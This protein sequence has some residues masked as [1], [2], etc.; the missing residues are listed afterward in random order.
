MKKAVSI[1]LILCI[2]AGG[3]SALAEEEKGFF[4]SIGDSLDNVWNAASGAVSDGLDAAEEAAGKAWDAASDA[5]SKA[6]DQTKDTAETAA[7]WV[8]GAANS[9]GDIA[10]DAWRWTSEKAVGTWN[11]VEN[12]FDPPSTEGNPN[13]LPE[14]EL[15]A[16]TQKMYLGYEVQK[17][18]LN[19]GY[20]GE[21]SIGHSGV[22]S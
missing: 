6:W 2:L 18:G 8:A 7:E 5:A 1:A 14:S 15:P 13:I 22:L 4:G 11:G 12:F 3:I 20:S 9:V 10:A 16:G 19:N 17:T 21:K